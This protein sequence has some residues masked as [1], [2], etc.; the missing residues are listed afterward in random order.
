MQLH[1]VWSDPVILGENS[2]YAQLNSL[3]A[4]Q[5]SNYGDLVEPLCSLIWHLSNNIPSQCIV[6]LFCS[7]IM[8]DSSIMYL[9]A[10]DHHFQNTF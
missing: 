1:M 9:G 6:M 10:L 4:H 7:F 2:Y 3:C 8:S 5:K